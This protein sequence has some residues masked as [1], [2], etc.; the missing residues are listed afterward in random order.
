MQANEA[1]P[2]KKA[3]T[4]REP[5]PRDMDILARWPMMEDPLAAVKDWSPWKAKLR[6]LKPAHWKAHRTYVQ[7]R[8]DW[9]DRGNFEDYFKTANRMI[10]REKWEYLKRRKSWYIMPL[11]W[12]SFAGQDC[13][14]LLDLGC[15]DGDPTQRI[16]EF[17]VSEWKRTG[18]GHEL[19]IV[20]ADLSESRIENANRLCESP[21][22]RITMKFSAL[23]AGDGLNF[24]DQHFDYS[25][26]IGVLEVLDDSSAH[27]VIQELC[28]VTRKGIYIE[29]LLDKYP[30]GYPRGD[31]N[32]LLKPHGFEV[33]KKVVVLTEPFSLFR[34]P[35]PC[36]VWPILRDQNTWA[37]RISES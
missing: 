12:E 2:R 21:D 17:I 30:G 3:S 24:P 37:E 28:R 32:A 27:V 9:I 16:A 13:H 6:W 36:G 31:M 14:R 22:P 35:D 19:E 8:A 23:D 33:K 25:A 15:G 1:S 18:A 11:G 26:I 7:Q 5:T 29:D 20:G 34:S 10:T 4:M